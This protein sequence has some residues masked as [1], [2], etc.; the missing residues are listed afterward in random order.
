MLF[1][2]IIIS[3]KGAFPAIPANRNYR[4]SGLV[5]RTLHLLVT[6]KEI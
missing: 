1:R 6:Q 2:N 5:Q 4:A 3:Q